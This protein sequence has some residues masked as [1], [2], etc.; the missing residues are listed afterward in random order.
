[1]NR[2]VQPSSKRAVAAALLALLCC[3]LAALPSARAEVPDTQLP[4]IDAPVTDL[5][6]VLSESAMRSLEDELRRHQTATGVQLAVLVVVTTAGEPI[7]DYS[8]RVAT[9][10][11]GGSAARD[12]GALYVLAVQDRRQRLEVGYGLEDRISDAGAAR[13]LEYAIPRLRNADYAGAV[14]E[15]VRGA[16]AYTSDMQPLEE[17]PELDERHPMNWLGVFPVYALVLLVGTFFGR[18][19]RREC[20]QRYT[21]A[22]AETIA[23]SLRRGPDFTAL[24]EMTVYV[25]VSGTF[26][27]MAHF[28]WFHYLAAIVGLLAGWLFAWDKVFITLHYLFMV[29]M[30]AT[31]PTTV[32]TALSGEPVLGKLVGFAAQLLITFMYGGSSGGSTHYAASGVTDEDRAFLDQLRGPSIWAGKTRSSNASHFGALG[33]SKRSDSGSRSSSRDFGSSSSSFGSS[34]SSSSSRSSGS[35][36]GYSGGGGGFG[37]GGASSSW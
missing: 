7:E 22:L 12:E 6:G 3:G 19:A 18:R 37:G 25:A 28:G 8:M 21:L 30:F 31:V 24:S 5:A 11:R 14:E 2:I 20:D 26:A 9:R 27:G 33:S 16:V 10:W 34:R 32:V 29:T 13:I 17:D 36:S 4:V 1:M 35:S 23:E 15:V